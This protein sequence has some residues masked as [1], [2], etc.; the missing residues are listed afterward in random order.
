VFTFRSLRHCLQNNCNISSVRLRG[1]HLVCGVMFINNSPG[2]FQNNNVA[3]VRLRVPSAVLVYIS[4]PGA[5][6]GGGG[7]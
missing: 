3:S 5:G 1:R 7:T 2:L 4:Q 6:G